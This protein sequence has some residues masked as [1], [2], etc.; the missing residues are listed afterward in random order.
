M[1]D[2][3]DCTNLELLHSDLLAHQHEGLVVFYLLNISPN[4]LQNNSSPAQSLSS[5]SSALHST[6]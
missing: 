3:R 2:I 1:I 6:S 5:P 4:D